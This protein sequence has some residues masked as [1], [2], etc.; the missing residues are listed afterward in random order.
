MV[1]VIVFSTQANSIK[2]LSPARQ[3]Q[4]LFNFAFKGNLLK[5]VVQGIVYRVYMLPK[6]SLHYEKLKISL[7]HNFQGLHIQKT[8]FISFE[9]AISASFESLPKI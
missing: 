5:V 4:A 7:K 2:C 1:G 8:L 6:S 3:K 9:N